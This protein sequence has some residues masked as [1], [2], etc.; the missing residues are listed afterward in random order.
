[1]ELVEFLEFKKRE[2]DLGWIYDGSN[3]DYVKVVD[4]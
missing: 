2:G 3:R 1:M 4:N